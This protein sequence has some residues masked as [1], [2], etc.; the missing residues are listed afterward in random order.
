VVQKEQQSCEIFVETET[1][2]KSEG[3]EHCN[4]ISYLISLI[5]PIGMIYF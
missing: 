3:A 1:E 2:L 5:L 4:I